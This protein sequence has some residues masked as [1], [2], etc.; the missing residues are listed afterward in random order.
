MPWSISRFLEG[1]P[2]RLVQRVSRCHSRG[3]WTSD[4]IKSSDVFCKVE[5]RVFDTAKPRLIIDF[6]TEAT[7]RIGPWLAAAA[8][9]LKS[10][11]A[12][13]FHYAA[14]SD[15]LG[16]LY[17]SKFAQFG[18]PIQGDF[19]KF[20]MHINETHHDV[21]DAIYRH[22][23]F[24][25]ATRAYIARNLR[26]WKIN[27]RRRVIGLRCSID[28]LRATGA[29]NTTFGN[30]VNAIWMHVF[31]FARSYQA[32][33]HLDDYFWRRDG[34]RFL[35]I[36]RDRAMFDLINCGDDGLLFS[37]IPLIAEY[38]RLG[39][40]FEESTCPLN[41]RFCRSFPLTLGSKTIW[42]RDPFEFMIR[43]GWSVEADVKD[44]DVRAHQVAYAYI[45]LYSGIPIYWAWCNRVYELTPGSAHLTATG[46]WTVDR[47]AV[48]RGVLR[49][50]PP[51]EQARI[52]FHYWT[53]ISPTLQRDIETVCLNARSHLAVISHPVL[54]A[55]ILKV[56]WAT[57]D[58]G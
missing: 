35:A 43:S 1:K 34:G 27:K 49:A 41:F 30:N 40:S 16:A 44:P 11:G 48:D 13:G 19:H 6:P 39:H 54:D 29:P 15:E 14:N 53:G 42:V 58:L 7:V 2:K 37:S 25:D 45:Q 24:D 57:A 47:W 23:G 36:L 8:E 5:T 10:V 3:A 32:Y 56:Q 46:S 33:Y 22:L 28:Y 31:R 38:E 12:L 50:D 9:H 51:S 52:Q 55:L 26:H 21:E 20:D 18:L 4:S 17:H